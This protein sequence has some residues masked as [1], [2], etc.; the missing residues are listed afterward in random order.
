MREAAEAASFCMLKTPVSPGSS[1]ELLAMRKVLHKK[2]LP[3]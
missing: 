2:D 1:L 3:V